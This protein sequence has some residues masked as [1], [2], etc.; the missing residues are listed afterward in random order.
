MER[1]G[2]SRI[3]S[4]ASYLYSYIDALI[5]RVDEYA[6]SVFHAIHERTAD[7][8]VLRDVEDGLFVDARRDRDHES[9]ERWLDPI[10]YPSINLS[11]RQNLNVVHMGGREP[12]LFVKI[13]RRQIEYFPEPMKAKL[14]N[15]EDDKLDLFFAIYLQEEGNKEF[16]LSVPVWAHEDY[17]VH[18]GFYGGD[19]VCRGS[20]RTVPWHFVREYTKEA[21]GDLKVGLTDDVGAFMMGA[22]RSDCQGPH[23]GVGVYGLVLK[24]VGRGAVIQKFLKSSD[25]LKEFI[26]RAGAGMTEIFTFNE[27][28]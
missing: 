14:L 7:T 4:F 28:Y 13:P 25:S 6:T 18:V 3:Y 26:E 10:T 2:E 8:P 5:Q 21:A 11:T 24:N 22:F 20:R 17:N 19:G 23:R 15:I 27:D 1:V 16:R 12:H 9:W